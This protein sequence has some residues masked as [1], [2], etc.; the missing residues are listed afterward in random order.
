MIVEGNASPSIE[1]RRVSVTVE[2]T[3]ENLVL[4]VAQDVAHPSTMLKW[5]WMTLA[6]GPSS[7]WCRRHC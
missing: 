7:W 1:G 4:S 2:V 6:G 3:G 5:S